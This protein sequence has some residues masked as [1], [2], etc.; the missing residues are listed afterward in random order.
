MVTPYPVAEEHD[1]HSTSYPDNVSTTSSN[2]S[3]S[4]GERI[5]DPTLQSRPSLGSRKSSGTII[6]PRDSINIEMQAEDYDVG[7][8]RTMS[9][10]RSSEEI[11]KMGRNARQ[12]LI[13]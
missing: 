13:L 12:A 7:D 1:G 5:K 2:S 6:I 9:P 11:E 4:D 3:V 8:A 10:R